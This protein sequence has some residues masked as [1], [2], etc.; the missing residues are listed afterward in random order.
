MS[1]CIASLATWKVWAKYRR[2]SHWKNFCG[3]RWKGGLG[4]F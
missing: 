3:C 1:F 2:F 4:P